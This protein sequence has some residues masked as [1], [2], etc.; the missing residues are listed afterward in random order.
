MTLTDSD[1]RTIIH[2]LL[3]SKSVP[4]HDRTRYVRENRNSVA[5][6]RALPALVDRYLKIVDPPRTC[7]VEHD[8]WEGPMIC[9]NTLPC[10]RHGGR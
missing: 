9:G 1:V 8:H 4:T 7:Q 5:F 6:L 2:E 10:S 3:D